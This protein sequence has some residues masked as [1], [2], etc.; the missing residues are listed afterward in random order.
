MRRQMDKCGYSSKTYWRKVDILHNK[1][2]EG[3][4]LCI[5]DLLAYLTLRYLDWKLRHC[6]TW[7]P[8]SDEDTDT[9]PTNCSHRVVPSLHGAFNTT[10]SQHTH[11]YN[12]EI[13]SLLTSLH[14]PFVSCHLPIS[15][16]KLY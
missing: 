12:S 13:T 15:F 3:D 16:L 14:S 2:D 4:F 1:H 11:T 8:R 5:R 10:L 9:L 7:G 6:W